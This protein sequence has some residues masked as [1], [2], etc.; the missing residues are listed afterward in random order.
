M[1]Q[2]KL[3]FFIISSCVFIACTSDKKG[4][5][6]EKAQKN[7]DAMHGISK[8]IESGDMSNLNDYLAENVI[9]HAA[10][11]GP[12]KGFENVKAEITKYSQYADNMKSEVIKELAD[13]DY[14]MCWMRFTGTMKVD[15]MGMKKGDTY[16]T[17]ALEVSKF[18]A[19]SK[20]VEHWTFVDPAEMAKMMMA[21][22]SDPA[23]LS[24]KI[25]I[26]PAKDSIKK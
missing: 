14:V 8:A 21:T 6:S 13:D 5:I 2:V 24:I 11:G 25:P 12:A 19:D 22:S 15:Q 4:G 20:A 3:L 23:E 1:I 16:N 9:D 26:E 10:E 17:T 18:N 7:L